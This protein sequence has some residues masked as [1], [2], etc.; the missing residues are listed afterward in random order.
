MNGTKRYW[1]HVWLSAGACCLLTGPMAAQGLRDQ[2][3]E[4]FRFGGSCG[5]QLLCLN[6]ASGASVANAFTSALSE[7]NQ[8][9]INLVSSAIG[10]TV[11]NIPVPAT[12]SGTVP[13]FVAG[14]LVP[15]SLSTGPI[16]TERA[17]TMGRGRFLIGSYFTFLN[18]DEMRGVP[19]DDLVFSFQ[20]VDLPGSGPLGDPEQENNILQVRTTLDVRVAAASVFATYGLTS[21][22]DIGVAVPIV[23]TSVSGRADAQVVPFGVNTVYT[24]GN[25]PPSDDPKIQQTNVIEGSASGIGD[26]AGRLKVNLYQSRTW[27]V[28]LLGD[29]RFPTGKEEELLGLGYLQARGLAITS[30]EF[31]IFSP[32]LN[33]GY[34]YVDRE[35]SLQ[36]HAV[37]ANL[38]FDLLV[39][40]GITMIADAISEWNVDQSSLQVP[41]PIH[42]EEPFTR[43]ISAS[44]IPDAYDHRVDASFGFKFSPR[45]AVSGGTVVLSALVPLNAGG[46]RPSVT[47]TLGLEYKF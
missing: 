43:T 32:H 46:L 6:D 19:M 16:Y 47:W 10:A 40:P 24:F 7:N 17:P 18:F 27:G 8:L 3:A 25:Q 34:R 41:P 45:A 15:R 22:L 14:R 4:L 30:A 35:Q 1:R 38:G 44:P 12:S 2:F 29:V 23:R 13:E 9:V 26:V 28:A 31:G 42:Y 33:L 36:N 20:H 21:W 37:L 5:D 39:T 11:A